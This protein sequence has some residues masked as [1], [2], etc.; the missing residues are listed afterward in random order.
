[1]SPRV[2]KAVAELTTK[3][4]IQVI[5]K[6]LSWNFVFWP[7]FI[8]IAANLLEFK[9][10]FVNRRSTRDLSV[11]SVTLYV[12]VGCLFIKRYGTLLVGQP[13]VCEC[14]THLHNTK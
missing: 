4:I 10:H 1:M 13:N 14:L 11:G 8:Y 2:E 7:N 9:T 12:T 6:Q 5:W 3:T